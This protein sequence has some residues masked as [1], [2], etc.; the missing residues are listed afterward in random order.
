MRT[1]STLCKLAFNK[2]YYKKELSPGGCGGT[3]RSCVPF[4]I[5]L[6]GMLTNKNQQSNIYDVGDITGSTSMMVLLYLHGLCKIVSRYVTYILV[7]LAL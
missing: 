3:T 7:M 1:G 6:Y 2:Y 5:K 4:P